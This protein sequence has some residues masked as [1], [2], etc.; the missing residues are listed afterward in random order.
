MLRLLSIALLFAGSVAVLVALTR[1]PAEASQDPATDSTAAP[2]APVDPAASQPT[3]APA[4]AAT[5]APA[6]PATPAPASVT[7]SRATS[8]TSKSVS[9]VDYDFAPKSI[10]IDTGDSVIWTN[11]GTVPEGHNVTG[12]G[13]LDSGTLKN[14]DTYGHAFN[15]AG[16]F[17]YVCT[18]HP[19]MKGTVKVVSRSAGS[20]KKKGSGSSG[21]CDAC[22]TAQQNAAATAG[23]S[24]SAAVA[25]TG[26]AGST[27]TDPS[28]PSTGS[29][30]M[31]LL[32]IGEFLLALGLALRL[33]A[34]LRTARRRA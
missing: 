14:G 34:G 7:V 24:E 17:S 30:S 6:T 32:A 4:P 18:L 10:T 22:E 23:S 5:P 28:L 12:D 21:G 29:D 33:A 16:T 11:N 26:A 13:G 1:S 8:S 15:S 31:P 20:N 2:A 19:L 9:I 3:P 27:A 25:A